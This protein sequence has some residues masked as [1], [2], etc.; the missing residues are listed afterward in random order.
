MKKSEFLNFIDSSFIQIHQKR[1]KDLVIDLRKNPGGDNTFSDPMVAY[2]ATKPFSFTS[3]FHIKTSKITKEFWKDQKDTLLASIKDEILSH[4]DGERFEAEI[5]RYP[6]RTD[7]LRFDGNVY[8]LVDSYSY[9]N[10]V[11]TAAIIQD[12]GFGVI[13]GERTA[14]SPT[15]LA[16]VHEFKLPVTGISVT[17]PKAFMVRPNGDRSLKGI[18][19][20]FL[21]AD[22]VYTSDDEILNWTL[23]HIFSK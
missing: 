14:D 21:I 18:K 3:S 1:A 11:T 4:K 5:Q 12:Y 8:V 7:S 2:F 16:S 6:H 22:D 9:S 20:D 19:P 10:A 17:Y 23:K 15:L 13:I